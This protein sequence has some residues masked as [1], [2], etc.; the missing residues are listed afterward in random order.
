[1]SLSKK[2]L[3]MEL[4]MPVVFIAMAV[5]FMVEAIP[6]GSE[7][8]FPL[9]CAVLQLGA[10]VYLIIKTLI[11]KEIVLKLEGLNVKKALLTILAL[12]IY[13]LV[14]EKIGYCISTFLLVGFIIWFLGYRNWKIVLLSAALTAAAT[15]LIFGVLLHVPLPM[16]FFK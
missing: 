2:Q 6:M 9:I 16:L 3:I 10:A 14:L 4:F 8:V 13:V 1:M 7:G 5:Y 15:Y 12:V 11:K